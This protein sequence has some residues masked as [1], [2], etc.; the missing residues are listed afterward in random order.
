[1]WDSNPH[2]KRDWCINIVYLFEHILSTYFELTQLESLWRNRLARQTVNLKVGGSSPPRD[3]CFC[4][5]VLLHHLKEE[6]KRDKKKTLTFIWGD[7]KNTPNVGLEPTTPRLRVSCSTDWA[8]RDEYA[9]VKVSSH[10]YKTTTNSFWKRPYYSINAHEI[11]N[12]FFF[13]PDTCSP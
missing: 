7:K 8:S 12:S 11:L 5:F 4:L 6:R 3:E 2:P 13:K 10:L 1:M 9:Q